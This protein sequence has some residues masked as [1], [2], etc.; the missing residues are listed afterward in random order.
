MSH[1]D[2]HFLFNFSNDLLFLHNWNL[3]DFLFRNFVRDYLFD[4]FCNV[5]RFF[6]SIGNESRNL[7]IQINSLSISDNERN[8]PFNLNI[9]ISFEDLFINNLNLPDFVL[10]LP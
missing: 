4:N 7:T 2:Q 8:L 1:F 9:T 6:L 5:D 10:R 3:N